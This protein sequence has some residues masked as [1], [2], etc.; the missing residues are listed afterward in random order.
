MS[1][2]LKKLQWKNVKN[3]YICSLHFEANLFKGK[4]QYRINFSQAIQ[5]IKNSPLPQAGPSAL[6]PGPAAPQAGPS[7]PRA[8]PFALLPGPS[9]PQAGPSALQRRPRI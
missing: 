3:P 9:A 5:D 2:R 6:Q 7:A 1:T 4:S 8:A